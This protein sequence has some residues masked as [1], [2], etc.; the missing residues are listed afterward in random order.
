[1]NDLDTRQHDKT[2]YNVDVDTCNEMSYLLNRLHSINLYSVHAQLTGTALIRASGLF[3]I[4]DIVR[5][6]TQIMVRVSLAEQNLIFFGTP[7]V[8]Y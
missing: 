1:M 2:E 5:A 4:M 3:K 6:S 7:S 8:A